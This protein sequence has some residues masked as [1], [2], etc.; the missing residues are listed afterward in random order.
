M[1]G[2][3]EM[4]RQ[5]SKETLEGAMENVC[6]LLQVVAQGKLE[7]AKRAIC[8]TLTKQKKKEQRQQGN[9]RMPSRLCWG[10]A[11]SSTWWQEWLT[12]DEASVHGS[13]GCWIRRAHDC[14]M[15]VGSNE[16]SK[17][18]SFASA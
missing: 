9:D 8:K 18:C 14:L 15:V 12:E 4:M 13:D 10:H 6:E 11:I 5:C 7:K 17:P 16:L 1:E 3:K 2:L